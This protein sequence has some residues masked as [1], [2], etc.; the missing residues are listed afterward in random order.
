MIISYHHIGINSPATSWHNTW[1]STSSYSVKPLKGD[2]EMKMFGIRAL[3][4]RAILPA[5]Y[6]KYHAENWGRD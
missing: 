1:N 5:V 2:I 6:C 4:S 3:V